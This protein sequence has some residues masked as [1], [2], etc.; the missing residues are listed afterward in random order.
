MK[1]QSLGTDCLVNPVRSITKE[2]D[3]CLVALCLIRI[4]CSVITVIAHLPTKPTTVGVM[5]ELRV[6]YRVPMQH[7]RIPRLLIIEHVCVSVVCAG[8]DAGVC[9]CL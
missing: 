9:M 1:E 3:C 5:S 4:P 2:L 8:R 7:S 6:E